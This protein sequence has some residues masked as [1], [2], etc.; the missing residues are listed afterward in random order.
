VLGFYVI[1]IRFCNLSCF[2]VFVSSWCFRCFVYIGGIVR[3]YFCL[4]IYGVFSRLC[5]ILCEV[6]M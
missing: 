6:G 4:F 1:L 2:G 5:R 3:K